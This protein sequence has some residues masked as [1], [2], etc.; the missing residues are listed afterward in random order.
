MKII[1]PQRRHIRECDPEGF[2]IQRHMLDFAQSTSVFMSTVSRY[3]RK[4]PTLDVAT[5]GVTYDV[6]ARELTLWFN[7]RFYKSLTDRRVLGVNTHE[8]YHIIL[9]HLTC[10]RREPH[11]RWNLATDMAIDHLIYEDAMRRLPH[12]RSMTVDEYPLP[13]FT[14]RP[15][16]LSWVFDPV[17]YRERPITAEEH[18]AKAVADM[19]TCPTCLL[20]VD[21]TFST[22]VCRRCGGALRP[23]RPG[24]DLF[25]A[26]PP[27]ARELQ[28]YVLLKAI[29]AA[30]PGQTS[31]FNFDYLEPFV[32]TC[33]SG[34]A[35]EPGGSGPGSLDDHDVWD[36]IPD[37]VL[38][39]IDADIRSVIER[40]VREADSQANGWGNMPAELCE[41]IRR[42]VQPTV[43]WRSVVD[44]FVGRCN[45]MHT[46]RSSRALDRKQPFVHP[47]IVTAH[48]PH[49]VLVI[50][51]SGSV[52]DVLLERFF[53]EV[54]ALGKQLTITILPFDAECRVEE[55]WVW[56]KG[57]RP[58]LNRTRGGGTDFDA[59]TNVI[60]EHAQAMGWE[61]AVFVTD[62]QCSKPGY[63]LVPRLWILG[64]GDSLAW[65]ETDETVVV[66]DEGAANKSKPG[67]M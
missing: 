42:S 39:R 43:D 57:E 61:G 16:H 28:S 59:P 10:R 25:K 9:R 6:A 5:A 27:T 23:F 36:E 11:F 58:E 34:G 8:F 14:V 17:T 63:C 44:H 51:Q 29:E 46:R 60:N 21:P 31:E 12:G 38:D 49:L 41:S 1:M 55:A 52:S 3:V 54:E 2:D 40:A 7:P 45:R 53:T 4:R 35:G 56:R 15:G 26:V 66:I 30:P 19:S 32:P 13:L 64:P 62:G 22:S 65:T 33:K 18:A 20:G 48:G 50:D 24:P 37:E 67:W 47:G